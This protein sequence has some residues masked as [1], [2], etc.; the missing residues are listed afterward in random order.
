MG[1]I[2]TGADMIT[3][4]YADLPEGLHHRAEQHGRRRVIY[5]RPGLTAGSA[6]AEP[7][8]GQADGHPF[9]LVKPQPAELERLRHGGPGGRV[10]LAPA[11]TGAPGSLHPG[12][13]WERGRG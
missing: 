7:A 10:P 11:R 4:R 9:G 3:I 12:V 1:G 6:A 13:P 2:R 8:P 5:L